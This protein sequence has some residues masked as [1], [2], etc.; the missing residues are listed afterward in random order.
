[1]KSRTEGKI[2]TLIELLVVIAIIAILAS[3]LLPALNKAKQ[4]AQGISCLGNIRQIGNGM[5]LYAGDNNDHVTP[6]NLGTWYNTDMWFGMIA[7]HVGIK[8]DN[9]DKYIPVYTCPSDEMGRTLD[10]HHMSYGYNDGYFCGTFTSY[11]GTWGMGSR[12]TKVK[13]PSVTLIVGERGNLLPDE[14]RPSG[15]IAYTSADG[16]LP[17]WRHSSSA[18]IFCPDGHA[19]LMKAKDL[20][21]RRDAWSAPINK[22]FAYSFLDVSNL[23]GE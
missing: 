13:F 7:S 1:M 11:G 22:Y 8:L 5:L 4:K 18:T 21:Y 9:S 15:E 17:S 3:M 12:L 6:L 16:T 14:L 2:F 19:Q 10:A 20:L 23:T